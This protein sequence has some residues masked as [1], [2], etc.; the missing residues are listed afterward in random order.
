[1]PH[2]GWRLRERGSEGDP[3]DSLHLVESGHLAVRASLPS[4]AAATFNIL[5]SG[6]YFGEL[7]CCVP[8]T[9]GPPP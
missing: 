5:G 7:A 1:M 4:G 8:S 6:D 9:G 3:A 2:G